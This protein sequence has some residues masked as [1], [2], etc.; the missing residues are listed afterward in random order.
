[1]PTTRDELAIF[2]KGYG[3]NMSSECDKC[4]Q[5]YL[6]CCCPKHNASPNDKFYFRGKFFEKEEDFWAYVMDFSNRKTRAEDFS[7]LFDMLKKDIWTNIIFRNHEMTNNQ[8][9]DLLDETFTFMIKRLLGKED[10]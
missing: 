2:N 6:D 7:G 8:V 1:M 9:T 3:C 4:G 5:H 10:E